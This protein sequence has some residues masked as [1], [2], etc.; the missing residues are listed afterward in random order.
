MRCRCIDLDALI[1][2]RTGK[3]PRTLYREG[4]EA[5]RR[6]EAESLTEVL[7]ESFVADR[8]ASASGGED[9]RYTVVSTGGGII[10]NGEA[11]SVIKASASRNNAKRS[12]V[13]VFL[14]VSA[15]T[16]WNRICRG[17][18]AGGELPPFLQTE[19]PEETHR[20][21]HERRNRAYKDIASFTVVAERKTEEAIAAEILRRGRFCR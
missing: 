14:E 7:R 19:T 17:V 6:A 16:A 12:V 8:A 20:L 10:D 2:T 9:T 1:E 3:T 5:F 18:E 15:K 11:V 21:L 13:L 4:V